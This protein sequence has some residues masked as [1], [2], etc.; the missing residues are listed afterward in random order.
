MLTDA[1]DQDTRAALL[2]HIPQVNAGDYTDR[3]DLSA[4]RRALEATE[5]PPADGP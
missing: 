2:G 5:P 1:V 3:T 4:I